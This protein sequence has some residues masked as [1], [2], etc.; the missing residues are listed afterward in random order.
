MPTHPAPRARY[1][2]RRAVTGPQVLRLLGDG[3]R[4]LRLIP[5]NQHL[6]RKAGEAD[7]P[8]NDRAVARLVRE[9]L[10]TC[11]RDDGVRRYTLTAA[12]RRLFESEGPVPQPVTPETPT[13]PVDLEGLVIDLHTF[14]RLAA[15]LAYLDDRLVHTRRALDGQVAAADY[16]DSSTTELRAALAPHVRLALLRAE[17]LVLA[18]QL[19]DLANAFSL[20]LDQVDTLPR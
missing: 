20:W 7:L 1:G 18:R 3:W 11:S 2:L 15:K 17:G 12:G 13:Y 9:G 8:V 16:W 4:L 19:R 10:L 5:A 6:L 14:Q